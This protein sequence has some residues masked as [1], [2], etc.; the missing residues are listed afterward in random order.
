MLGRNIASFIRG[1]HRVDTPSVLITFSPD[2]DRRFIA[3]LLGGMKSFELVHVMT[4]TI[5]NDNDW[6]QSASRLEK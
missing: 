2:A 1:S 6:T 3:K 4:N 5:L